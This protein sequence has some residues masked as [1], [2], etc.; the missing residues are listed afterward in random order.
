MKKSA[1]SSWALSVLVLLCG[2][3][4]CDCGGR[5]YEGTTGEEQEGNVGV[6]PKSETGD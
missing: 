2:F 4:I 1:R 6:H 3:L 5:R